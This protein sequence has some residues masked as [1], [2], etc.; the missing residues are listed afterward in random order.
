MALIDAA[1]RWETSTAISLDQS[2][3][4]LSEIIYTRDENAPDPYGLNVLEAFSQP[5][6]A[7]TVCETRQQ[8]R[9]ALG[10]NPDPEGTLVV[11]DHNFL[12]LGTLDIDLLYPILKVVD[13]A[14]TQ[15]AVAIWTVCRDHEIKGLVRNS[16]LIQ[17]SV[18]SHHFSKDGSNFV[19]TILEQGLASFR[20]KGPL[21]QPV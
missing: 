2:G 13:E 20:P 4:P 14:R 11:L 1:S 16:Q 8:L 21:V 7:I 15:A 3:T 12:G 18:A 6:K 9:H 19:P 5:L 10:N 17:A